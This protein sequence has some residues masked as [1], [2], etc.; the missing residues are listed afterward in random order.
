[1]NRT[2]RGMLF[3]SLLVGLTVLAGCREHMP[4]SFTLAGGDITQSH[5]KP[6]EGGYYTNWDPFAI[7]IEA[8]PTQAVNPVNT[9]HVI[10]AT[11]RDK[12][13]KTLPNRR[14]EWIIPDGSVGALVEVDE[15]GWRNSRGYKVTQKYAVTHTNNCDHVLTRG[16]Q[17]PNDDIHLK[18]G[19]TWVVITS[20]VEGTTHM[21]VYA[22][23]VYDWSKHKVFV[24]KHWYDVKWEF[25]PAATNPIGTDHVLTSRIMR[26]SD[27]KPLP[28]YEVTYKVTSGPD[29]SLDS[30]GKTAMVTTDDQG[31]ASTTLRQVN[32]LAGTN[33]ISI[34]VVRPANEKC[35]RPKV[36]L[37]TGVTSKT[38][39]APK[40]AIRKSAPRRAKVGHEFQYR[41]RVWNPS[42]A[43]ATD[44][45]VTDNLPEGIAYVSSSPQADTEGQSL[46]WRLGTLGPG[47][48]RK[49]SVRVNPTRVGV[50][51]NC[52]NATAAYGLSARACARTVVTQPRLT[53]TKKGPAEVLICDSIPYTVT[54]GN[55]G[56]AA[57]TN[58]VFK[59][60]LPDGLTLT[61]GRKNITVNVGTLGAGATRHIR[62][63]AK[64]S[65]T[66]NYVNAATA[67]ADDNLSASD[68]V[69][70]VVRQP[71]LVITKTGPDTRFLN[72]PLTYTIS[73]TNKGDAVAKNT[74][75]TDRLPSGASFVKAT[76]G[77]SASGS[78]VTWRLGNLG[79]NES[80]EVTVTVKGIRVGKIKNIASVRAYCA[81]DDTSAMT[82]IKGV[83]AILL[84]TIDVKDPVTVGQQVTYV[85]SV[86]NQGT[87]VNTN[88]VIRCV[89]PDAE[90]FVSATGPT[91]HAAEGQT[92]SFEPVKNLA[93]KAS[94]KYRVIVKGTQT[95]DVRFKVSLTSDQLTSPVEET[96]STR[97][98]D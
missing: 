91:K 30:G 72:R 57:A 41:M 82:E 56:S 37:A 53:L 6:A 85:I 73:V 60:T 23:G 43:P 29:A 62:Y 86:T 94:V 34:D 4:H 44:V 63:T 95:G 3:V 67:T 46:T 75:L 24:K 70:T 12:D 55:P 68:S 96:E 45:V 81:K 14:V 36:H 50:F 92:V 10:V 26:H 69:T 2:T 66:G 15:S 89:L 47:Q 5:A 90:Q 77:G 48:S 87:A 35:C 61:D 80:K 52:A 27:G 39:I 78:T 40:I 31:Y 51:N 71:V 98:Y 25:P 88:I 16:N 21:I 7:T 84:E 97:I 8:Y 42:Q 17:D 33:E 59:D 58:V 1:M 74:V 83:P 65:K 19:Q 32:P 11:V 54:L 79:P 9:Q 64:A 22:P 18:A 20:P 13:G 38:W 76:G 49:L 93:P 28:G